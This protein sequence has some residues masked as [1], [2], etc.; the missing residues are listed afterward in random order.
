MLLQCSLFAY[1]AFKQKF[2]KLYFVFHHLP[3]TP[4]VLWCFGPDI[5][6][7]SDVPRH[8]RSNDLIEFCLYVSVT[9]STLGDFGRRS[10]WHTLKVI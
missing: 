8:L 6:N 7:V 9:K 2:N 5:K 10:F 1:D 4:P 3:R